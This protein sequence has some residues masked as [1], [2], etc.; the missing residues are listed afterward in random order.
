MGSGSSDM[1]EMRMY[2]SSGR[3]DFRAANI[4]G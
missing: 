2:E 3:R 4:R 1:D